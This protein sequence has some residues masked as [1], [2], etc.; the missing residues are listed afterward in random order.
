MTTISIIDDYCMGIKKSVW[1]EAKSFLPSLSYK[2][3]GIWG[4]IAEY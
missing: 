4:N 1:W 3:T 2:R